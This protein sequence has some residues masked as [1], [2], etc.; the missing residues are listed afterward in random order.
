[1]SARK[2]EEDD[3]QGGDELKGSEEG[4]VDAKGQVL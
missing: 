3:Q 2:D 4:D 1:M